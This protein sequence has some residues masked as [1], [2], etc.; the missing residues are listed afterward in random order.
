MRRRIVLAGIAAVLCLAAPARADVPIPAMSTP[1]SVVPSAGLPTQVTVDRS[2]ANL[3]VARF[4]G[5]VYLV[6]RTAKW[7]I[8]DDNARLYVISSK[9]QVHWRYEGKF[10]YG[11]D[12]RECRLLAFKGHLYLYFA[13]LGSNATT[14]EPG[15]TLATRYRKQNSWTATRHIQSPD[16]IPWGVK[17]HNGHAYMLGYTGGGGTFNTNPP[18]KHVYWLTTR[19]GLDWHPVDASRPIVY[20]GQCGETDF[21]FLPDGTLV[22]ACQTEEVDA[23]GWGAKICT[24]PP[25]HSSTWTCRGDARRLD[26]PWV[27]VERGQAYVIAR[28]Q[29]AFG[30]L[31]DFGADVSP[32][33]DVTFALY[34]ASYA[35]TTKRCALWAI[36]AATRE[37]TPLKDVPGTGDTCYP[38]IIRRSGHRYLVYNY[39]SPLDSD[40]PWGTALLFGTTFIYRQTLTF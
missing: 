16:F 17:T 21:D 36:D 3:S 33:S 10:A 12:V 38:S 27:F 29:V 25:H 9:D 20:T 37:F 11:R 39:T 1:V 5:R 32:D 19:N 35:A 7:Q 2:N 24:A 13:L 8:A 14:F 6:F 28:R 31:Y 18:P 22:A 26:S 34:D 15:G 23:L 30:G 4:K 40:D